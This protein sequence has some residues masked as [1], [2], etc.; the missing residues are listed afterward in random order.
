MRN[1]SMHP[2]TGSLVLL[3]MAG[4]ATISTAAAQ[5]YPSRPIT[6][7]VPFAAGGPTDTIA[8][9]AAEH[10]RNSLGQ[11]I[12]IE[13][14]VG[15]S[16]TVGTGRVARAA[17]DGYTVVVGFWGTHV[18]NGALF[19]LQYDVLKDFA[20]VALLATNPQIIVGRTTLPPANLQE[21]IAW[22]RA[23]PGK[24]SQGTAG[25]GSPAHV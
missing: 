2:G 11:S 17:P 8:R 16:G 23:N 13:N 9:I 18:L 20:P 21:L 25:I 19:T 1:T 10:M 12:I 15:A 24:A 6:M 14:V 4:L 3:A 7:V 22:L 5:D